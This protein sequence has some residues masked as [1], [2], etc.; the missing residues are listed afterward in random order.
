MKRR[1][2]FSLVVIVAATALLAGFTYAVFTDQVMSDKQTFSAGT[3]NI[4]VDGEDVEFE[5][6]FHM[7]NMEP[8]DSSSQVI[9]INNKGSLGV[10]YY[11]YVD[12]E[13]NPSDIWR[14]DPNGYSLQA[15]AA[16][17]AGVLAAGASTNVTLNA[18]LPLAAGNDCQGK[19]GTLRV[20]VHAVQQ[21]NIEGQ[22]ACVKLVYKDQASN[23]LPYGPDDPLGGNWNGQHGNVCYQVDTNGHLRVIVNAYDLHPDKYYQLS[24]NGPGGCS[25]FED[26]T[27]AGMTTNLY[28]SGW[29]VGPPTYLSST[30]TQPWHEGVY[31]ILGTDGE[32]QASASGNFSADITLDGSGSWNPALPSGTYDG[33]KFIVKEIGGYSGSA[34]S[35]SDHGTSWTPLLMEIRALSFQIP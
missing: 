9:T 7:S 31:N 30:C 13:Y 6:T 24:L 8:G 26:V 12:Y 19:T 5:T 3:V 10:L 27:F 23:W 11:V 21:S 32:L 2:L 29:W 16:P 15:W 17:D 28:H 33:V 4:D 35:H 25:N 18:L 34:P 22:W 1:I 14:C 20:T